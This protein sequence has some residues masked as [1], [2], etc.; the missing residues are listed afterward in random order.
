MKTVVDF[1][2]NKQTCT[3]NNSKGEKVHMVNA[4]APITYGEDLV[5]DLSTNRKI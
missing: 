2:N 3:Y 5:F 1:A 4:F